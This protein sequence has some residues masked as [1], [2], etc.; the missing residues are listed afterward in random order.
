[1]YPPLRALDDTNEFGPTLQL[2]AQVAL[3]GMG[4]QWVGSEVRRWLAM[5]VGFRGVQ[6]EHWHMPKCLW[7]SLRAGP[8]RIHI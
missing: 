6:D 1:M 2:G 7:T 5:I 8:L 3:S 4:C